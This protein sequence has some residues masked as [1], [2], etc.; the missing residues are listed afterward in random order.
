MDA[1][2]FFFRCVQHC[3]RRHQRRNG[4]FVYSLDTASF[5]RVSIRSPNGQAN[6]GGSDD[7][8]ISFDGRFVAFESFASDLVAGDINNE[9][10]IFLIDR[11]T[12]EVRLISKSVAGSQA[13][14]LSFETSISDDGRFVAFA[15]FAS[16]LVPEDTNG[17]PDVFVFDSTNNLLA[18]ASVSISGAQA[19]SAETQWKS[20]AQLSADGRFLTYL[21]SASIL[22]PAIR[23]KG[24]TASCCQSTGRRITAAHAYSR[25]SNC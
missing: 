3:Q 25:G 17:N 19:V 6:T 11:V 14:D 15:S 4:R 8:A 1:C 13:N 21:S 16:N 24:R 18:R 10:D 12:R 9:Q 2:C 23:I 5:E 20:G 22:F 7:P